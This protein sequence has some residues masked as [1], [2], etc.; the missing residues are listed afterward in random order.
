MALALSKPVHQMSILSSPT[1]SS[2]TRKRSNH[3]QLRVSASAVATP[4][5]TMYE[6]LSVSN[7]AGPDEIKAAFRREARRWHPD[8][9]RSTD[10]Q[11]EFAERFMRAKEAYEVLS[12]PNQ[13]HGY[14]LTLRFGGGDGEWSWNAMD[15]REGFGDQWGI[16]LEMLKRRAP[17]EDTWAARMR[18]AN[19]WD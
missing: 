19:G 5:P 11:S 13:R 4:S 3:N 17:K 14:D 2:R 7:T 8:T 9:C 6:L 15:Q 1:I 12:D 18:R 10:G 16:Q